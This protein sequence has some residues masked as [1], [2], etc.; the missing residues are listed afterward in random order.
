MKVIIL[1]ASGMVGQGALRECLRDPQPLI[2]WRCHRRDDSAMLK[3]R[4]WAACPTLSP[5]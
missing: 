2:T 1:G 3:P 4:A 5:L